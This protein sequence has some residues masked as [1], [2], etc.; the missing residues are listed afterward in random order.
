MIYTVAR[1]FGRTTIK[2]L[3]L[4]TVKDSRAILYNTKG[5]GYEKVKVELEAIKS[6]NDFKLN[7]K[8]IGKSLEIVSD[9]IFLVL[10]RFIFVNEDMND[11]IHAFNELKIKPVSLNLDEKAVIMTLDL[12]D[13]EKK[14]FQEKSE[15]YDIGM[16]LM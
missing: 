11:F 16:I 9:S 14:D 6:G 10:S 12:S 2:G 5:E 13:E 4:R 7:Y 3:E 15:K 1:K 8:V